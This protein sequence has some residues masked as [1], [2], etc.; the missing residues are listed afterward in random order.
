MLRKGIIKRDS[1]EVK[2]REMECNVADALES[3]SGAVW[4]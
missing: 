4:Y 1:S 3:V 2:M